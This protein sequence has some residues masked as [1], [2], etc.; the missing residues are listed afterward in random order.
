MPETLWEPAGFTRAEQSES[1]FVMLPPIIPSYKLRKQEVTDIGRGGNTGSGGSDER[2]FSSRNS[3]D[4]GRGSGEN[5]ESNSNYEDYG[6]RIGGHIAG[7][8]IGFFLSVFL[9][10]LMAACPF[11]FMHSLSMGMAAEIFLLPFFASF[12]IPAIRTG[13]LKSCIFAVVLGIGAILIPIWLTVKYYTETRK[14]GKERFKWAK[15]RQREAE[16]RTEKE[17]EERR[18][19][20]REQKRLEREQKKNRRKKSGQNT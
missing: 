8:I 13:D 19:L 6:S 9:D 10:S 20:K 4:S 11:W 1:N 5:N 15:E 12:L 17:A 7:E 14:H 16:E 3:S 18:R 2:G